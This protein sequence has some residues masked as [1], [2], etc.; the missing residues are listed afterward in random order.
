[1]GTN[2]NA[3]QKLVSGLIAAL[4]AS[5]FVIAVLFSIVLAPFA[6]FL[7]PAGIGSGGG[8]VC[9][10]P[11]GSTPMT[12]VSAAT[13]LAAAPATERTEASLVAFLPL[14]AS[15]LSH[16][17]SV[18]FSAYSPY[19]HAYTLRGTA[20]L[21]LR[22]RIIRANWICWTCRATSTSVQRVPAGRVAS[23]GGGCGSLGDGRAPAR[24][25]RRVV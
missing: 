19:A 9:G 1:M 8:G 21:S 10:P 18:D 16:S 13:G 15:Q 14:A 22:D 17:V 3:D 6:F 5:G 25:S 12:P 24:Q 7:A 11:G 23:G 2:A 4:L 20:S